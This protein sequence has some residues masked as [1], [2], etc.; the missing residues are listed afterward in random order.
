MDAA[1]NRNVLNKSSL[2]KSERKSKRADLTWHSYCTFLCG[3]G[4][5]GMEAQLQHYAV[6][7]AKN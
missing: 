2:L 5:Y 4:W 3:V 7:D 1:I 6:W